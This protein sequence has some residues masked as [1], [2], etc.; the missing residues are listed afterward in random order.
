MAHTMCGIFA[1]LLSTAFDQRFTRTDRAIQVRP[2]LIRH[3]QSNN[4]TID[5]KVKNFCLNFNES[6]LIIVCQNW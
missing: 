3:F 4:E 2:S 5:T 1:A 6:I